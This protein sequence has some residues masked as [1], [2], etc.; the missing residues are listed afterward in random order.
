MQAQDSYNMAVCLWREARGES[1]NA[2]RGIYWTIMNRV[3]DHRWPDNVSKVIKQPLQFS[4]FNM[5]DP[6]FKVFPMPSTTPIT[7]FEVIDTPGDD[8]T[9]GATNY[10][11][12][13]EGSPHWPAWATADKFTVKIDAFSFYRL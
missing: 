6:N 11:S 10:H 4:S 1:I 7:I 2:Q 13:P 5:N 9:G 12:Y 3:A 8:P